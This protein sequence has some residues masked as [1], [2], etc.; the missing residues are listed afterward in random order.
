M[1]HCCACSLAGR[2]AWREKHALS[3]RTHTHIAP[4]PIDRG[5]AAVGRAH[6]YPP[7]AAEHAR[8]CSRGNEVLLWSATRRFDVSVHTHA[9]AARDSCRCPLP[10]SVVSRPVGRSGGGKWRKHL[11]TH[12]R[13]TH[14]LTPVD[15]RDE[16]RSIAA[17]ALRFYTKPFIGNGL[18]ALDGLWAFR[19]VSSASF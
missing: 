17:A 12:V 4:P 19:L 10:G 18:T 16:K 9:F 13:R 6:T 5:A 1:T 15:N 11:S 8:V 7:A 3:Q 2:R 14:S